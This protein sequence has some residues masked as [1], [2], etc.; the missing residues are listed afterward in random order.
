[1]DN[2]RTKPP[3]KPPLP[4]DEDGKATVFN[5]FTANSRQMITF[6][7]S[8]LS[9]FSCFF[10]TFS[11]PP[12]LPVIRS[13]L[14]LS[15][16]DI[17]TAGAASFVGSVLSRLLMGPA[18]DIL[19]PRLAS[20]TLSLV[21]APAILAVS[22]ASTPLFFSL[23]RLLVGLCLGNFV[24]NQFWTSTLFSGPVVGRANATAAGW[25]NT[26]SGLAQLTMPL[27]YSLIASLF[28]AESP[29]FC[30]RAA[31]ILPAVFQALTAI[32]ILKYT[33]DNHHHH[34]HHNATTKPAKKD[35]IKILL[36]GLKNYRGWIM[37]I[38][39]GAS[40]GVELT[41]DNII[42]EYFYDEYGLRLEVAGAVAACFGLGNCIS[43]PMGGAVSDYMGKRYGVRGRLWSLWAGLTVAGL[44]CVGLGRVNTL[45]GSILV[46]CGFSVFVQASSGM[47]F[48]VVP[49]VS[50]RSLGVISGMT[51]S[52]GTLGAVV[53]QLVFFSDTTKMSTHTGLFA[54]GI[55]MLLCT[56]T[57]TLIYSPQCGGV[58]C[59]PSP[60]T[61]DDQDYTLLD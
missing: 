40:F 52:G 47:V 7:L 24:A 1:M 46:M 12:L 9:L 55:A 58:F 29:S 28:R 53:T 43:R 44:L 15:P 32:L 35:T 37:A 22:L 25:A 2:Q 26:G 33:N 6:H 31:L 51:G 20:A 18:C 17:A 41:I 56:C 4:V 19:G 23:L 36:N 3:Q 30:W 11:I 34:H 54:M 21:T 60:S 13:D 57:V 49:F 27:I 48:G 8:W 14:H 50:T 42:A 10:S 59:A 61:L 39:Y 38:L 45:Y 5:P 16:S